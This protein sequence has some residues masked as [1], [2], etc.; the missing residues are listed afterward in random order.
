MIIDVSNDVQANK[1]IDILNKYMGT[2]YTNWRKAT[3]RPDDKNCNYHIWFPKLAHKNNKGKYVATSNGCINTHNADW[4]EIIFED[5]KTDVNYGDESRT[6]DYIVVFAKEYNG[7]YV[8]RGVFRQ[9]TDNTKPYIYVY[10]KVSDMFDTS[11][12][13]IQP[14]MI[15]E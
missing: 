2:D 13:V 14:E 6:N 1:I 5:T 10:K 3:W 11:V 9:V 15:N 7:S 4:T 8:F 12:S